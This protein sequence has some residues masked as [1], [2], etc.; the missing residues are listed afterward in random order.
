MN[1][2]TILS[3]N[4]KK[5]NIACELFA[6]G[7]KFD[8]DIA[9]EVGV[10]RQT[11]A[12][13]RV[14]WTR[15]ITT[16]DSKKLI[17]IKNTLS[18]N[19]TNEEVGLERIHV[20][21]IKTKAVS[22]LNTTFNKIALILDKEDALTRPADISNLTKL[23]GIIAPYV[24]DKKDEVVEPKGNNFFFNQ[25]QLHQTIKQIPDGQPEKPIDIG[26]TEE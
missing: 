22:I 10:V 19:M 9:S 17:K 21:I 11:V 23:I 2:E 14:K 5:Y 13:W 15:M 1:P 24:M 8:L 25:F 18:E 4:T 3:K 16:T 20:D 12:R 26:H 7:T 6:E